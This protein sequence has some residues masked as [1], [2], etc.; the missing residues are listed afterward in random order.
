[1]ITVISD[2]HMPNRAE[3]IP[4]EFHEKLE[5]AD[6]AVHCGDFETE[7][8]YQELREKYDIIG[9]KGNCDFFDIEVSEKFTKNGIEFGVYHGAG[10]SPRGH[11]PTLAKTAETLNVEVLFHGHT[12]QQEIAEHDG[13]ILLNAGSCTGVGGG[14]SSEKNPSM[15][16]VEV[17]G[18]GEIEVKILEKDL[19][20]GEILIGEE[21]EL[22]TTS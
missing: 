12:H 11:H 3:K 9:V 4:E 5:E 1:M 10:I 6:V 13:K 7:E 20:T 2:S 14:S 15:M 18:G 17:S 21:R 8:K 22:E 19:E 16:R